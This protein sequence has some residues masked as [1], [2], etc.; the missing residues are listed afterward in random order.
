MQKY[1][2][3]SNIAWPTMEWSAVIWSVCVSL[4]FRSG[5]TGPHKPPDG[6]GVLHA[7]W[8]DP[9]LGRLRY[10]PSRAV[11]SVQFT[12]SMVMNCF[13]RSRYC[14]NSSTSLWPAPST[15][16]GST[17][18]GQRSYMARPWE[19]SITSSS[20]PCM[21]RTGDVIFDTLSILQQKCRK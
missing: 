19:K 20:V 17:A 5:H 9:A 14:P 1:P 7:L 13:S 2:L 15:H 16:S 8:S 6:V 4:T 3:C 18:R 10:S 21:T 12:N 11:S